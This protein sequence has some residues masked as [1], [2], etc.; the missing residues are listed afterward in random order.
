[1]QTLLLPVLVVCSQAYFSGSLQSPTALWESPQTAATTAFVLAAYTLMLSAFQTIQSEA[2]GLWMLYTFP[3]PL[4]TVLA[5]KARLWAGIGLVYP[6][7]LFLS[8][9]GF[10]AGHP[11]EYLRLLVQVLVG[12]PIYAAI[13]VALGVHAANPLATEAASRVRPAH[14]YLFMALVGFYS[15][16]IHSTD[17]AQQA[18]IVVLAGLL[19][20]AF[21][22]QAVEALPYLLDPTTAPPARVTAADGIAAAMLFFVLQAFLHFLLQAHA[23]KDHFR[24]VAGA[25]AGAAILTF[26]VVRTTYWRNRVVGIPAFLAGRDRHWWRHAGAGTVLAVAGGL[27][28]QRILALAGQAAPAESDP[29]L[30]LPLFL[31]LV[32]VAAPLCEEFLFRGLLFAGL[33]RTLAFGPAALASAGVFAIVHPPPAWPPVFLL[34][35]CTAWAYERS[36]SLLAP[37]LLHGAYNAAMVAGA[38]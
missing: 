20:L 15:F 1:V 19:A 31:G 4:H 24:L 32:S 14:L 11:L 2:G 29:T 6:G 9:G 12:V 17:P 23:G 5:Q 22:Q 27:A 3:I 21:W 35:L 10:A 7:L 8:G 26:L 37:M 36:R 34:G 38:L 16:G 30:T 28:W 33:R 18:V 25:Y 13:A